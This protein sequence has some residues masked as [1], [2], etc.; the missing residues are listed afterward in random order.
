MY[1][2]FKAVAEATDK[3]ILL[4]NVPG[5]T[6]I[7]LSAENTLKLAEIPNIVGVKEASSNYAQIAAILRSRPEGF[8]VFSGNDDETL[9]LMATGAEGVISVA[10]N[11]APAEVTELT[12]CMLEGNYARAREIYFRLLPLFKNCFVESNPIP[13]KA[14]LSC[15]GLCENELRLPLASA[16]PATC[17]LMEKTVRELGLIK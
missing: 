4:Y 9:S 3:P 12:H 17:E 14:A 6:G 5:R 11:I 2:Y 13:A 16:Q 8:M 15:M 7:N 1:S 10:S